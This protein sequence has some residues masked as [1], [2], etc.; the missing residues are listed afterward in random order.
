[1]AVVE[2]RHTGGALTRCKPE[3]GARTTLPGEL[4]YF[5][6][7]ALMPGLP[8]EALDAQAAKVRGILEPHKAEQNYL[9][10]SEEAGK[11]ADFF[12]PHTHGRLAK[13]KAEYDQAGIFQGNFEL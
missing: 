11:L 9:N 5:T 12:D 2:L 1:M 3:H 6:V 4:L 10:F 13:I 8:P 7:G